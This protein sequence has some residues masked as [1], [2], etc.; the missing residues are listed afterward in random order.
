MLMMPC[1]N[2]K[3]DIDNYDKVPS[4]EFNI[5]VVAYSP[6]AKSI[7]NL[8]S[9]LKPLTWL[10]Q[11]HEEGKEIPSAMW[12]LTTHPLLAADNVDYLNTTIEM[13]KNFFIYQ[14]HCGSAC[15]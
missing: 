8:C 11:L 10:L 6:A 13:D 7:I 15:L 4:P 3:V 12:L 5:Q 2:L 9:N 14:G 1:P